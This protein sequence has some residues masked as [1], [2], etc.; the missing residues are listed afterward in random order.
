[1]AS[2]NVIRVEIVGD[3]KLSPT[4]KTAGN[5]ADTTGGK[6]SKFK[7]SSA[8]LFAGLA[9]G[10]GTAIAVGA[11]LLKAG[12]KL[13][14]SQDQFQT[15]L[16]DTHQT[17]SS[18]TADGIGPL[19]GQM[20]KWGYTNDQVYDGLG[21]LVRAGDNVTTATTDMSLAADVAKGR[22]IDLTTAEQLLVKVRTGH[23]SLLGRYGIAV[24][25]A[26]GNII[27]QQQA[28][29]KLS[30]LYAGSADTAAESLTGKTEAM[31][32]KFGDLKEQLGQKLMPVF[33][34]AVNWFIG[35]FEPAVGNVEL[36][37]AHFAVSITDFVVPKVKALI[38]AGKDVVQ[39]F[40][41]GFNVLH[42]YV[43]DPFRAG[44]NDV[45]SAWDDTIGKLAH[46][47]SYGFSVAGHKIGITLPDL[48]IPKLH[49][50]GVFTSAS[51]EGLALLRNGEGVFTPQQ[52]AALGGGRSGGNIINNFPAGSAPTAVN[53]SLSR[54]QRRNGQ[55]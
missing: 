3:D 40:R 27:S 29:A 11:V 39:W 52:M 48:N 31:R 15:A 53:A 17:V 47:Q 36:K 1:M 42:D 30:G 24:K 44:I 55:S 9:A 20:E 26:N 7:V 4:L 21:S 16:R 23:V 35:T 22:N 14:E 32:A 8:Q 19:L 51:G 5:E 12:D 49:S 2:K 33:Y 28:I 6:F 45:I 46:G 43:Y 18:L 25:D 38:Q 10:V 37:V 13:N 54:W 34:G 41:D 50:G